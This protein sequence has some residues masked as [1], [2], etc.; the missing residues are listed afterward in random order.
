VK[1][2]QVWNGDFWTFERIV[3]DLSQLV[4][5]IVAKTTPEE[6]I[7]GAPVTGH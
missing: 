3:E 4:R 5:S 6:A 7:D 1:T 2:Y